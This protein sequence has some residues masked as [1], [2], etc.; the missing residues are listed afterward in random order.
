MK[1]GL[2]FVNIRMEKSTWTEKHI[3]ERQV[4]HAIEGVVLLC[5][6]LQTLESSL[7]MVVEARFS[8]SFVKST[9]L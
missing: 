8:Y 6:T 2:C 3:K 5:T 4:L 1:G 9:Q 7:L